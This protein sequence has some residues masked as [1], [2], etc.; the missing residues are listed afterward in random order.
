M[1]YRVYGNLVHNVGNCA[2]TG[3]NNPSDETWSNGWKGKSKYNDL[4]ILSVE[5]VVDT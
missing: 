5:G 2:P 4:H 1:F 3:E